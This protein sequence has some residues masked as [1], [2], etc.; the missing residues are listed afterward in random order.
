[1]IEIEWIAA[2]VIGGLI[3]LITNGIA[4]KMLFRPFHPVKIGKWT[5]P[6]TPGLI[7]KEQGRIAKAIGKVVGDE[8]LDT[9]TLQQALASESLHQSLNRKIDNVIEELGHETRSVGE[10]LEE[11]GV[12]GTTDLAAAYVGEHLPCYVTDKLMEHGVGETLLDRAMEEVI[13]NLSPML[14]VMA[15]SAIA[16]SRAGILEK[17][18]ELIEEQCPEIIRGYLDQEVQS[19]MDKPMKEVGVFLWDKKEIIKGKIWEAYLQILEKK[20][21]GFLKK[22]DV[23]TIVEERINQFDMQELENMIMEIA[24][25][26]LRALV[27]IGGLLGM[28]I[29]FVNVLF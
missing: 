14:A 28:V 2:P 13:G 11:K 22:L 6:F 23:S 3:G 15:G 1:M 21:A 7:P 4:L 17:M 9:E 16:S 12:R 20:S 26:E 24:R 18:N 29:G 19:W 10:I 25:K 5:L 8:L 27:W